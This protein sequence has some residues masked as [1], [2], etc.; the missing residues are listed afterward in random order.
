MFDKRRV[1]QVLY[2]LLSNAIKFTRKGEI[3]VSGKVTPKEGDPS[4]LV[5]TVSVEDEGIGM[6]DE[7]IDR[8]FEGLKESNNQVNRTLNPYSNGIG[9]SFC[10]KVC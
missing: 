6:A 9:L 1:Q 7:E 10:K 2:N 4:L 3:T 8:V 5:L